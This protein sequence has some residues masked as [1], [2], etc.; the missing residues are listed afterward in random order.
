MVA[1]RVIRNWILWSDISCILQFWCLIMDGMFHVAVHSITLDTIYIRQFWSAIW[2]WV[3]CRRIS[4]RTHHQNHGHV[5]KDESW[6]PVSGLLQLSILQ[7]KFKD[8]LTIFEVMDFV[9]IGT[10]AAVWEDIQEFGFCNTKASL[11]AAFPNACLSCLSG[12]NMS[13]QKFEFWMFKVPCSAESW[14]FWLCS[15]AGLQGR[16]DRISTRTATCS[17]RMRRRMC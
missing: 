17:F 2:V 13:L 6:H 1:F 4:H 9:W 3:V 16:R 14:L 8:Y 7:S 11:F 15:G 12:E 5:E 10:I